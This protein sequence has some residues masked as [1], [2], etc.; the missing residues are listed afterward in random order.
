MSSKQYKIVAK[1]GRSLGSH[2]TIVFNLF[3][4]AMFVTAIIVLQQILMGSKSSDDSLNSKVP[5]KTSEVFL[6]QRLEKGQE[7][8]VPEL[9]YINNQIINKQ[10]V[11]NIPADKKAVEWV[12]V[13]QPRSPKTNRL[14]TGA[15]KVKKRNENVENDLDSESVRQKYLRETHRQL[16]NTNTKE[17]VDYIPF[18]DK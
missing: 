2:A 17:K 4:V 9:P 6:P 15:A 13:K 8:T 18:S 3:A 1:R 14:A 10:E 16:A 12:E 5:A 11:Q 7:I